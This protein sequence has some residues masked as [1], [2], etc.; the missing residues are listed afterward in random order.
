M[1]QEDNVDSNKSTQTTQALPPIPNNIK[2]INSAL[3][4]KNIQLTLPIT[5]QLQITSTMQILK[6]HYTIR[7]ILDFLLN[8]LSLATPT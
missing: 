7:T 8:L 3:I 4:Q 2:D 5:L 6:Q 1:E